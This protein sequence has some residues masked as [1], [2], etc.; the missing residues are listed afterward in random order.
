MSIIRIVVGT[1]K[2]MHSGIERIQYWFY[3]KT[4]GRCGR[5]WTSTNVC[6]FEFEGKKKRIPNHVQV[7]LKIKT[8]NSHVTRTVL[9]HRYSYP[10]GTRLCTPTPPDHNHQ[11]PLA[12]KTA[13]REN[14]FCRILFLRDLLVAA[15]HRWSAAVVAKCKS[16][17]QCYNRK[18]KKT[19][20]I[21]GGRVWQKQSGDT[22]LGAANFSKQYV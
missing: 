19:E 8:E 9:V 14:R 3:W 15:G 12:K 1:I 13:R 22:I 7:M 6:L 21:P 17:L 2:C 11:P 18:K 5:F 4:R 16:Y 20:S 10:P